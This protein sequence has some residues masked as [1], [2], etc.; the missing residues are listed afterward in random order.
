MHDACDTSLLC[1]KI[2]ADFTDG[3]FSVVSLL[4]VSVKITKFGRGFDIYCH[5]EKA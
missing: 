2:M 4:E 5:S 3:D 1:I